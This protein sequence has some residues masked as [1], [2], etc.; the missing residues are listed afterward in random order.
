M[1]TKHLNTL[2]HW[3]TVACVGVAVLAGAGCNREK[4]RPAAGIKVGEAHKYIEEMALG[5]VIVAYNGVSLTREAYDNEMEVKETLHKLSRPQTSAQE[6]KVWRKYY[7]QSVV[8]EFLARQAILQAAQA[9]KHQ[10]SAAALQGSRADMCKLLKVG[11]EALEKKFTEMGRVGRNLARIM[12]E[13]ALMRSFREAEHQQKL[14]VSAEDVDTHLKKIKAYHER[15]EATNQLVMAKGKAI[16]EQLK[17]GED[18]IK[19]AGVYSEVKDTPAGVWGEFLKGEIE[20]PKIRETAFSLPAGAVS[21]PIDTEEGLVILKI[22]ERT[23]EVIGPA[24]VIKGPPT[25]KL[26][27][28]L[29]RMADGG[30]QVSLPSREEAEKSLSRQK[31][32]NLQN[33]WIPALI[34][35]ALIEYPNGTNLWKSAEKKAP[36]TGRGLPFLNKEKTP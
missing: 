28:I 7:S 5:D 6:I 34:G 23:E 29:L 31:I 2:F 8:K 25:V 30:G 20:N 26:G 19:L 10:P 13:N 15:C 12:A 36:G 33:E 32:K 24:A 4:E 9:K 35:K 3:T 17:R 27:R 14:M 11:D 18:F 1:R 16:C 22:L 21:E